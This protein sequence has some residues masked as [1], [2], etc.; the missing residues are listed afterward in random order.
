MPPV[1]SNIGQKKGNTAA[2]HLYLR[3][4]RANN[5]SEFINIIW[6]SYL[7]GPTSMSHGQRKNGST[8]CTTNISRAAQLD[9][10]LKGSMS[11]A[12]NQN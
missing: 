7:R 2:E 11:Q 1:V 9:L 10:C 4:A 12:L 8:P 3:M 6:T 5:V